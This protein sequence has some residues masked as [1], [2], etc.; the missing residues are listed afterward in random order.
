MKLSSTTSGE[1]YELEDIL[2]YLEC[3]LKYDFAS[4]LKKMK[5]APDVKTKLQDVVKH[6]AFHFYYRLLVDQSIPSFPYLADNFNNLWYPVRPPVRNLLPYLWGGYADK[7]KYAVQGMELLYD[8]YNYEKQKEQFVI[9]VNQDYVI[10][11]GD[12]LLRGSFDLIREIGNK[13]EVVVIMHN[14]PVKINLERDLSL[15]AA[16]YAFHNL[17]KIPQVRLNLFSLQPLQE[18]Y[19]MRSVDDYLFFNEVVTRVVEAIRK[20]IYYPRISSDCGECFFQFA[21]QLWPDLPPLQK[22]IKLKGVKK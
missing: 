5:L 4:Q 16:S 1:L 10:E 13:L 6:T 19:A 8:F 12:I 9:A 7:Q 20:R 3:P 14:P 21:C 2:S 18:L 15:T 11:V 22:I 17:Y